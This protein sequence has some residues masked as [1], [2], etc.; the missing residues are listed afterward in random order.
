MGLAKSY[1][2]LGGGLQLLRE[3]FPKFREFRRNLSPWIAD[4]KRLGLLWKL[5]EH[6]FKSGFSYLLE[7]IAHSN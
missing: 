5:L 1:S 4:H 6:I 7:L 3:T 2:S